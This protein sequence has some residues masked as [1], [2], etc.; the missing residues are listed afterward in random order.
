M[1]LKPFGKC[2]VNMATSS[3]IVIG[4][5]ARGM[6]APTIT[7][8]PPSNS[9]RTVAHDNSAAAGIP[10]ACKIS[11]KSS[12]GKRWELRSIQLLM[13]DTLLRD[14]GGDRSDAIAIA[15]PMV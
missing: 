13:R 14:Y 9:T 3:T 7:K 11:A 15:S 1:E 12:D 6:N 5:L 8:N 10:S 4:T 2:T